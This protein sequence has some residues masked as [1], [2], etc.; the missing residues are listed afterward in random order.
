MDY[1]DIQDKTRLDLRVSTRVDSFSQVLLA[2]EIT[3]LSFQSL[4]LEQ[5]F[6]EIEALVRA[7]RAESGTVYI[8]GNGGSAAIASHCVIDMVNM[9]KVRALS[10]LDPSVTTCISNDYGYEHVYERQLLQF[11]THRDVVIAISSSGK[12][13]NILNAVA[14][15]RTCGAKVITLSGFGA[16]NPLRRVGDFNLWLDAKDYGQVE[17]GHAFMLHNLTDRLRFH[18]EGAPV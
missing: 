5:G 4:S 15:A 18:R 8:V 2:T 12:S 7:C 6:W 16:D 1:V 9:A 11:A 10:M 3:D 14:A 13:K 17:I